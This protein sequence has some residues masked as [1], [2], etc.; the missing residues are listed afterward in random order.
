MACCTSDLV[1]VV[2]DPDDI[3]PSKS[4]DFPSWTSYAAADV[5]DFHPLFNTKF[6]GKVMLMTC[7]SLEEWLANSE[8]TE[9]ERLSPGFF[10]KVRHKVIVTAR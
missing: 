3:A 4:S 8:A 10:I 1:A 7:K 6:V 5:Q 9:M 2:V